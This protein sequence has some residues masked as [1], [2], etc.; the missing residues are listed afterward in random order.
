MK[1]ILL[2]TNIYPN[3]DPNYT[4]TAV[5]H[6]FTTEWIRMGYTVRVVHF[7]SLFPAP[8]YWVGKIFN[9]RIKAKT[10][11]VAYTKT[12]KRPIRYEVDGVKVLFVPLKK[13]IPHKA[14][15]QNQTLK[16]FQYVV[17]ELY[18]DQFVPDIITAHFVLPQLQFLP[19]FK[20]HYPSAKTCLVM[21]GN[22]SS[23]ISCYPDVYRD[24]MRSVDAWG[25]RS[26][27]FQL[28]FEKQ[29][30]KE[31]KMFLC[32]SGIPEKYVEKCKRDFVCR[33]PRWESFSESRLTLPQLSSR[34]CPPACPAGCR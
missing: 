31:K 34:T 20:A 19:L 18:K 8:Y 6:S 2:L 4:G 23:I 26:L 14:P 24:L 29:F 5:C 28:D 11:T 1:N 7:D 27:A 32:P 21:H 22:S 12:P 15:S 33:S 9:E 13:I 30:G 17:D 10:G 16:A 25:F 3:N